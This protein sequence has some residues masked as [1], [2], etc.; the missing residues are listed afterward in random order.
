MSPLLPLSGVRVISLAQQYPGPF[1]TMMLSDLGADVVVV[2]RPGRGDPTRVHPSFHS[3]LA[4]GSRSVALDLKSETGRAALLALLRDADALLEG[5]RPG[6][7]ARLG[8]DA[9]SV[10]RDCP[11]LVY[12]SISGFGQTGPNRLRSGH[13]LTYQ[14][15]AGMLYEHLPPAAAPAPPSLALGDLSAGMFAAQAVL[16]GLVQRSRTG[17]G[18]SADVAMVDCL[19][20]L[21]VAHTGPVVNG[22]GSAGF[23]YEPGYGVFVTSDGQHLALAVAHEDHFWRALCDLVGMG[24]ERDLDSTER[25]DDHDRL[26]SALQKGIAA[27]PIAEW[28]RLLNDADVPYGRLRSLEEQPH[29]AQAL[30]R[31]TFTALDPPTGVS[32]RQPLVIDGL[33]PGP[34]CTA[35][36]L[37]EHTTQVLAEAG[38]DDEAISVL[39][40]AGR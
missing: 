37:G 32:V 24:V 35:P 34:G 1:A 29:T 17:A 33:R 10:R 31:E 20:T 36:R 15:E 30:A 26:R 16:V 25:F 28:E 12:V 19:A 3:T 4:R 23:P 6:V 14:A 21:L 9:D 5:F 11:R 22:T 8:L 27:R 38:M 39:V 2:E 40:R 13:D 7:M 18:C